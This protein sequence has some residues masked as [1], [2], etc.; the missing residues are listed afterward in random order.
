[1][2]FNIKRKITIKRSQYKQE[3]KS[4]LDKAIEQLLKEFNFELP[5]T[6]NGAQL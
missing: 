5:N 6:G 4:E 2:F 3:S 1:M